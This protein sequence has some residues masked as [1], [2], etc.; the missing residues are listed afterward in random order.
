MSIAFLALF[1][2]LVLNSCGGESTDGGSGTATAT[3]KSSYF[4]DAVFADGG[5]FVGISIGDSR[6][7][8]KA[9]LPESAFVDETDGYLYYEWVLGNNDY[10][11]D[12]YFGDE[13]NLNSIDGYIY[14]YDNDDYYDKAEAKKFYS[15]MEN[16]FNGKFGAGDET[17]DI[18]YASTYWSKG[19]MEA[20]VSMDEG[21]VYWYI[22]ES[23]VY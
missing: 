12:L 13:D 14:F 23:D 18:D 21:E 15:D 9:S 11:L 3:N 8:V 22:Y 5:D 1:A 19:D 6:D 20:E 2:G 7:A 16:L 10:Y 4:D 17:T